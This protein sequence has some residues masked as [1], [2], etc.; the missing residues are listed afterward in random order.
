MG[1]IFSDQFPKKV[2]LYFAVPQAQQ[3][4]R[5]LSVVSPYMDSVQKREK[6]RGG[7]SQRDKVRQPGDRHV[8]HWHKEPLRVVP[9][10]QE[11]AGLKEWGVKGER[12]GSWGKGGCATRFF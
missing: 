6:E 3:S 4:S 1:W 9:I 5:G 11:M 7:E 8:A 12:G 10:I 2:T